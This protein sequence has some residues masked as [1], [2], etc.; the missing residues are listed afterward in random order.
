MGPSVVVVTD[1]DPELP[2]REAKRL[3]DM[4]WAARDQR[5]AALRKAILGAAIHT[6]WPGGDRRE[7]H[8]DV[9]PASDATRCWTR[10]VIDAWP[11]VLQRRGLANLAE[12]V[13]RHMGDRKS[14]N[15]YIN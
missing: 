8:Q 9:K 12:P 11:L 10:S 4:L 7:S 13:W 6:H 2:R 3:A 15:P 1:N 5:V 14:A